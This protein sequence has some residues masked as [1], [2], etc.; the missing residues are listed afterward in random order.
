MRAET[1]T[2]PFIHHRPQGAPGR[3]PRRGEHRG[4]GL[5][6]AGAEAE[7]EASLILVAGGAARDPHRPGAGAL[8]ALL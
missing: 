8:L 7:H 3:R 5:R 6:A 2:S 1:N 4:A